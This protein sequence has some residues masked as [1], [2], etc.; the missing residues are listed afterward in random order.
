MSSRGPGPESGI[1]EASWSDRAER[2]VVVLVQPQHPGN[3]GA[4]I[5]ALA[6]MGLHR[7]VVV[8]PPALDPMRVRWMAPGC[9]DVVASMRIV[10]TL[11]EA[12]EGC[13]RAIATTAR[14]RKGNQPVLDPTSF[15]AEHW[16]DPDEDLVT[17]LLFGREDFGLSREH[18]DR[19]H[20][21]LRIPTPEHAS[22]NLAQAVLVVANHWFEAGRAR[23]VHA[24]G[25]SLGGRRGFKPTAALETASPRDARADLPRLEPA[26]DA[27]VELL[28]RVGYFRGT[29]PEKVQQTARA[30]LQGAGLTIRQVEALRGMIARVGYALD[31]PEGS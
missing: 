19:C 15:S 10:A 2:L 22:L 30:A 26:A 27:L 21:V 14:H 16:D 6:N 28:D 11:D 12:L 9:D 17:A 23:G 31:H 1:D 29:P 5:R 3:V 25:R 18:V 8:D 7:L 4:C 13:H 20:Q 24:T